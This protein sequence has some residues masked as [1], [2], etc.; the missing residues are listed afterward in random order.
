MTRSAGAYECG[1]EGV[2]ADV[3]G[4][5]VVGSGVR[6]DHGEHAAGG[7][8]GQPPAAAAEEQCTG[9]GG[10]RPAA[11]FAD[12]VLQGRAQLRVSRRTASSPIR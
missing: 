10:I 3:G 2:P 1:G 11:A 9:R 6:G 4:W 12:P 5:L 7:P 8:G